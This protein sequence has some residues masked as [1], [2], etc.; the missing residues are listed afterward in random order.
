MKNQ[1][2]KKLQEQKAQEKS[3]IYTAVQNQNLSFAALN[4]F[5]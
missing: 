1:H 5:I 4:Q 3:Y 2:Q